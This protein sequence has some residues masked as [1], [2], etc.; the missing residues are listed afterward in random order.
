M[1]QFIMLKT[2]PS[3]L[4]FTFYTVDKAVLNYALF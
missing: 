3:R 1:E 2:I 4:L